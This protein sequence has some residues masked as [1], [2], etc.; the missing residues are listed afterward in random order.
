MKR[1]RSIYTNY[2]D[3]PRIALFANSAWW[4]RLKRRSQKRLSLVEHA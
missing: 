2:I 4:W 1:N 3:V